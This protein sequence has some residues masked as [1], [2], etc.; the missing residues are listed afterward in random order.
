MVK[1]TTIT[2]LLAGFLAFS[3]NAIAQQPAKPSGAH[4]AHDH[5]GHGVNQAQAARM[6][7]AV[8]TDD[9]R[10]AMITAVTT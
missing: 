2:F 10:S 8:M 7:I 6:T 5:S 3:A 4:D 9:H 1:T